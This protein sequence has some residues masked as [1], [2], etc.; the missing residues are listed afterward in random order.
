[1]NRF[2]RVSCVFALLGSAAFAA[3]KAPEIQIIDGKVSMQAEAVPLG[4]LLRLLDAATGM[5]SRVPA[6]LTNR[7][8]SVRFTGL[9]FDAAVKKLFEG[10]P[11]D[12]IVIKGKGI[13]VTAVAQTTPSTTSG[14]SPF[15]DQA[16]FPQPGLVQDQDGQPVGLPGFAGVGPPVF[17]Q[18]PQPQTVQ[19]VVQTPFGPIPAQQP[20]Q[21]VPG[22]AG[23]NPQQPGPATP[24]GALNPFGP[25]PTN[26]F[27][28]PAG[29]ANPATPNNPLFGNTAPV[30]FQQNPAPK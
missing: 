2:L 13:M 5:T 22:A 29:N 17:N 19:G 9:P 3:G 10:Q 6:E 15:A 27:G 28:A 26:P 7:N 14:P 11:L 24:F 30:P 25:N 8:V 23:A 18:N 21:Q 20:Q 16:A 12:Y 1:M 4:R